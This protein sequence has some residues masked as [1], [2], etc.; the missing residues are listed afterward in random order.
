[1]IQPANP[2]GRHTRHHRI[3]HPAPLS[4]ASRARGLVASSKDDPYP[5]P[6]PIALQVELTSRC[7]LRCRMCPL[8]TGTSSSSAAPGPMRDVTFDEV[9]ALARRCRQVI[10]AGYGE[11]FSS[12]E[13]LPMIRA[14]D[15]EGINISLSTNGFGITPQIAAELTQLRNVTLINV[16]IDSPDPSTYVDL[17]RGSL[18][19]ALQGL[20]NLVEASDDPDRIQ[21]SSVAM[22]SNVET[23]ASFPALLASIGV[24]RYAVQAVMDYNEFAADQR[25]LELPHLERFI[26]RIRTACDENGIELEFSVPDRTRFDYE[27]PALARERFYG[28]ADSSSALTRQCHVPWELPFVDKDG[29]VFACCFAASANERPFG[30]LGQQSFDEIWTGPAAQRFRSDLVQGAT[31]PDICRRCSVAPLGPHLFDVWAGRVEWLTITPL[32]WWSALIS[33]GVLNTGSGS[34]R[35]DDLVRI[36]TSGPR[37][38]TT[39]LASNDWTAPN[40]PAAM[41]EAL[42]EPGGVA[43]FHFTTRLPRRRRTSTEFEVVVDGTCW[44]PNTRFTIDIPGSRVHRLCARARHLADRRGPWTDALT[45]SAPPAAKRMARSILR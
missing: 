4:P 2:N 5:A 19:R 34:W 21:V 6:F 27:D 22:A 7:N 14:L 3:L 43:T 16:S 28:Q 17:R 39:P 20:R 18:D 37:D 44:L 25:L 42:V 24:R 41:E 40:R 9:L 30:Q 10:L 31:T 11:P 1:M 23:L 33:V 26:D 45:R 32:R 12:P 35:R 36:G 29:R 38:S 8:T 15:A 13:S